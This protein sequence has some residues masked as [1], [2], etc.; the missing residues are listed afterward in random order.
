MQSIQQIIK[1]LDTVIEDAKQDAV[2]TIY[3]NMVSRIFD[4]GQKTDG[5]QIGK[6]ESEAYKEKRRSKGLQVGFVDLTFSTSLN[7]S[8]VS[9]SIDQIYFNNTYG[10]TIGGFQDKRYGKIF[11]ATKNERQIFRE[12]LNDKLNELINK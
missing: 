11:S 12:I 4:K 9:N 3:G 1:Q 6:Y 2:K 5:S 8:V 7:K 10:Q